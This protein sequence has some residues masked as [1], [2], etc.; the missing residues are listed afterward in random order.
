M[1][2][3]T[4]R[5]M[6]ILLTLAISAGCMPRSS[7][8]PQYMYPERLY[9]QDEPCARLYV[10]IDRM[11]RADFPEYLVDELKAFLAEHCSKPDGI[12]VVLDPPIP[13]AEFEDVPLSLASILCIDGPV[14]EEGRP[15]PAYLHVFVYDGKAM[16][17]GAKRNPRV[18]APCPSAVFW[19]V[20]FGRTLPKRAKIHFLRHELGHILGLCH[21]TAH[22]DGA[23]CRRHGCLMYPMPDILSQ[24]GGA[25]HLYHREHRLCDDCRRD[26]EAARQ[27]PPD[28]T[29][30]F[31]GPLL[32]RE[33]DGYRVAS[34]PF[35]ETLIGTPAPPE[36]DW[37]RLL[38][39]AKTCARLSV[40]KAPDEGRD[41]K[42]SHEGTVISFCGRPQTE[43]HAERLE[44]DI[45]I[46]S[47]A[48][49]DPSPHVSRFASRI[50]KRR[51]DALAAQEQ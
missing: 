45:A 25:V 16:F 36:S 1:L 26:L 10:E 2:A 22:G 6:L 41:L 14:G 17:K 30:S 35:F 49:T 42:T 47:R 5:K 9:L 51:Q 11:Q 48:A 44:Q 27:A 29:L 40:R 4:I 50:L 8:L 33:A 18:I 23:H 12:E 43:T 34:L 3:K 19:N 20:D 38:E 39:H 15:P 32:L 7:L 24:L 31:T 28:E 13:A 21:N 37:K 46:L